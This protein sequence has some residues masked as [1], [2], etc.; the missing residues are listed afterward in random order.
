MDPNLSRTAVRYQPNN[1][2]SSPWC[3]AII[4]VAPDG[5][6]TTIGTC[7]IDELGPELQAIQ[8]KRRDIRARRA[9][10]RRNLGADRRARVAAAHRGRRREMHWGGQAR[11]AA[12]ATGR[13]RPRHSEAAAR[14]SDRGNRRIRDMVSGLDDDRTETKRTSPQAGERIK[15]SRTGTGTTG[16]CSRRGGGGPPTSRPSSRSRDAGGSSRPASTRSTT[17]SRRRRTSGTG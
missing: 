11:D 2:G 4:Q 7:T 16:R 15:T 8:G 14:R 10:S 9:R 5:G 1:T 17:S 13:G 12:P 3:W 6:E